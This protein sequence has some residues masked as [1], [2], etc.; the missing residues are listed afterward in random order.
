M[1][2]GIQTTSNKPVINCCIWL[3]DS[4]ECVKMHGPTNPKSSRVRLIITGVSDILDPT[5]SVTWCRW[6][7]HT[8][9]PI[10]RLNRPWRFQEVEGP[11]FH[12]NRHRKVV[13]LSVLRTGHLYPQEIFLVLISVRGWVNFRAI[14][15]PEG[16][17][18]WKIPMTLS[19]I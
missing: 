5:Q 18:Q 2:N 13:R 9:N 15:R 19:G 1:L 16:L 11:R 14:V 7:C 6:Q 10:S 4:F 17:Y 12:D 3:V 8:H